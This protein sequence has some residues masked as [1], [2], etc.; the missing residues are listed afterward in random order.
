MCDDEELVKINEKVLKLFTLTLNN[1]QLEVGE[2][3]NFKGNVTEYTDLLYRYP[4][5]TIYWSHGEKVYDP[6]VVRRGQ[7]VKYFPISLNVTS[8]SM[9]GVLP[10]FIYRIEWY[11]NN[12]FS[13]TSAPTQISGPYFRSMAIKYSGRPKPVKVYPRVETEDMVY[14]HMKSKDKKAKEKSSEEQKSKDKKAKEK[15]SEGQK[16]HKDKKAKEK[17]SEEQEKSK[18]KESEGESSEEQKSKDK[19]TKEKKKS[20]DKKA[21]DKKAKEKSSE[22]QKS[23]DKKA[24][25]KSSEGQK[26]HKDKKAKEK[27]SEEQEKSKDKE[28]EGESSEEQKSKDKKKHKDKKAKEKSSKEQEKSTDKESKGESSEEQ[29]KHKKAKKDSFAAGLLSSCLRRVNC[30][31]MAVYETPGLFWAIACDIL[32]YHLQC[33]LSH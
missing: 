22:E 9:K 16:K 28:S 21:K 12:E 30:Y 32:H 7:I 25:E 31:P 2:T 27:S 24:K 33:A 18:D 5:G 17:S 6:H 15:S 8:Y 20:K 23:K 26:K 14:E 11:Q 4:Q 29:K 10:G 1:V 3:I 13:T 19:K